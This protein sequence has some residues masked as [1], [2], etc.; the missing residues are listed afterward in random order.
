MAD[1]GF[2][3]RNRELLWFSM[4]ILSFGSRELA[5]CRTLDTPWRSFYNFRFFFGF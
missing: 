1:N 3:V 4:N 5:M 2:P